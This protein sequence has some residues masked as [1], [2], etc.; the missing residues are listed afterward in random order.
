MDGDEGPLDCE[1]SQVG[2]APIEGDAEWGFKPTALMFTGD[3]RVQGE[4]VK[5]DPDAEYLD[6]EDTPTAVVMTVDKSLYSD[7]EYAAIIYDNGG[8]NDPSPEAG[9]LPVDELQT[10]PCNPDELI[11]AV[12]QGDDN[13]WYGLGTVRRDHDGSFKQITTQYTDI[14]S[15]DASDVASHQIVF[16]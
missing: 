3:V 10:N 9:I 6:L 7:V 16:R 5:G 4:M 2:A 15:M 13:T 12:H 8:D 11:V 1:A 14:A